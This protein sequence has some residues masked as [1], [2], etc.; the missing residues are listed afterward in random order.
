MAPTV[1]FSENTSLVVEYSTRDLLTVTR[2][3][4]EQVAA[5]VKRTGELEESIM[6][7]A[8]AFP[9]AAQYFRIEPGE[10]DETFGL[11]D[12][13]LYKDW[14]PGTLKVYVPPSLYEIPLS[15]QLEENL[16]VR[17]L[18]ELCSS[19]LYPSA[20]LRRRLSAGSEILD[21]LMNAGALVE[22]ERNSHQFPLAGS[23]GIYRL[24]HASLLY[25]TETTGILVDPHLHSSFGARI[26]SDVYR[27]QLQGKVDAVLISHFHE[28][29]W[30]LSTLLM[31]PRETPI[32]VPK[33][34]RSTVICGD[35]VRLLCSFGFCNV[36]AVDWNSPPL[37][38]GDIEVYVLPFYGEQPLRYD[39][40]KQPDIRNWGNTYAIR[41]S[42]YTSWFLIDSGSDALGSMTEV[43]HEV[44][45]RI[46]RID[47]LLSNLRR[48]A[49]TTPLYINQGLNWLSLS[50]PQIK[51]FA[52]MHPHC[53]TLG[54]NGVADVCQ[55]VEARYYLPYAHWWG[56]LG[57]VAKPNIDTPGQ[58]EEDLVRELQSCIQ[59]R[60]GFTKIIPWHIGD[61]V[62]A[63]SRKDF[64]H[65]SIRKNS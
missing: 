30:F 62:V 40:P 1:V 49:I 29:H 52:S 64:Q 55:T 11:R 4:I 45:R 23:P 35:M 21:A 46:G 7:S 10:I 47:F 31:F 16:Q 20:M 38:F 13:Y 17:E 41:T 14:I 27:D 50:A 3:F 22:K 56:E 53:I 19:G 8:D 59:E 28:D 58:H 54:P 48:F 65:V 9:Q 12:E 34:P 15:G 5:R 37:R 2:P 51:K 60:R 42:S 44:R 24:Q 39:T 18:L 57:E 63:G 33:V 36:I 32:V 26:K 6:R 25:R 43:A 61:A